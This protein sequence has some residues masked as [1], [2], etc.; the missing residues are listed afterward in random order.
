ML[1]HS[2]KH[3]R[4]LIIDYFENYVLASEDE[5]GIML[6]LQLA[7]SVVAVFAVSTS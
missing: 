5:E 2:P 1:A 3:P 4:L 6:V 7:A